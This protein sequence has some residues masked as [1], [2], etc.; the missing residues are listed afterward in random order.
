MIWIFAVVVIVVV[1]VC[2]AI[3]LYK[4]GFISSLVRNISIAV[5]GILLLGFIIYVSPLLL[6]LFFNSI[7][8]PAPPEPEITYG[9]FP[10]RLVYEIDGERHV[11]EDTVIAE[12]RRS[13]GGNLTQHPVRSWDT[14][15]ESDGDIGDEHRRR[16]IW[17]RFLIK[18]E[19]NLAITFNPGSAGY[20]MGDL[21]AGGQVVENG[22]FSNKRPH[23]MVRTV[24]ENSKINVEYMSI[25]EAYEV[26]ADYGIVL[27]SWETAEPIVN[28]FS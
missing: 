10:F 13:V 16:I 17:N 3:V 12:F 19:P 4:F 18:H 14:R 25:E 22:S 20:Y 23:I 9:E 27:I 28:S 26:L 11:F 1:L 7:G 24:D 6:M 21:F 15:F 5:G 2:F 8:S